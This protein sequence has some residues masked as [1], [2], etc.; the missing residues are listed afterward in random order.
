MTTVETMH[1]ASNDLI[2]RYLAKQQQRKTKKYT[3]V[4]ISFYYEEDVTQKQIDNITKKVTTVIN[5]AEYVAVASFFTERQEIEAIVSFDVTDGGYK[6]YDE[7]RA[8]LTRLIN[9]HKQAA[10]YQWDNT[11]IT[12]YN[13]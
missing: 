11:T 6:I 7:L 3:T 13:N 12:N 5:N 4:K 8:C 9:T 1:D 2:N 10:T